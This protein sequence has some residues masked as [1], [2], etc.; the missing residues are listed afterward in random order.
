MNWKLV[1]KFQ[2]PVKTNKTC[3]QVSERQR[4]YGISE[5]SGGTTSVSAYFCFGALF[6][7]FWP[8]WWLHIFFGKNKLLNTIT[9]GAMIHW[10]GARGLPYPGG[11]ILQ[12]QGRH[13][14]PLWCTL[15]NIAPPRSGPRSPPR[16]VCKHNSALLVHRAQLLSETT[17]LLTPLEWCCKSYTFYLDFICIAYWI[18]PSFIQWTNTILHL[19]KRFARRE[20]K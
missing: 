13:C 1:Q 12:P 6:A 14:S 15:H 11:S 4:R 17:L 2:L 20:K 10:P 3:S 7:D 18:I 16:R 8:W 9:L 19:W 5:S